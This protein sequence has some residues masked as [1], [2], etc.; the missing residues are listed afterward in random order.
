MATSDQELWKTTVG[1]SAPAWYYGTASL[2]TEMGRH[3]VG[4]LLL[5][6]RALRYLSA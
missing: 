5:H 6:L 1:E 2:V 3:L 4:V